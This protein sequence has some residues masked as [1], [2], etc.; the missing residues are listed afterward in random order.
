MLRTV[1]IACLLCSLVCLP[2]AV[3]GKESASPAWSQAGTSAEAVGQFLEHL[4]SSAASAN[5]ARELSYLVDF[6]LE[7]SSPDGPKM[8]LDPSGFVEVAQ[9]L[10]DPELRADIANF[11]PSDLRIVDGGI[12]SPDGRLRLLSLCREGCAQR[13]LALVSIRPSSATA[14]L[15]R[16][17]YTCRTRSGTHRIDLVSDTGL[18]LRH[19]PSAQGDRSPGLTTSGGQQST[20]GS[21]SCTQRIWTFEGGGQTWRIESL[22]CEDSTEAPLEA[23][24]RVTLLQ[25][26]RPVSQDWCLMAPPKR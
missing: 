3:S 21:G 22:G 12:E 26:H 23:V 14:K 1:V 10:L 15:A 24:G 11:V 4:K 8:V 9:A 16:P 25:G 5:F 7:V 18:R 20:S 2:G 6:P 19:W 17:V 13:Q